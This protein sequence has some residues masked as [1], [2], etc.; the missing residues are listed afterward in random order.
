MHMKERY[1]TYGTYGTVVMLISGDD[2]G[3]DFGV[4]T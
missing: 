1:G 3:D 2:R 4:L